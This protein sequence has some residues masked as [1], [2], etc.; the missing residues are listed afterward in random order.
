MG[1]PMTREHGQD[2]DIEAIKTIHRSGNSLAIYLP[3]E[4]ANHGFSH[5]SKI[6]I[7]VRDDIVILR[8][9]E[10]SSYPSVVKA[11]K[12]NGRTLVPLI[13]KG[14]KSGRYEDKFIKKLKNNDIVIITHDHFFNK[15][16]LLY[17]VRTTK[18]WRY[19]YIDEETLKKITSSS[20]LTFVQDLL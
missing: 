14:H 4:L 11:L 2:Y 8:P 5:G 18:E 10:V 15:L 1:I 9:V 20:D 3:K 17:F 19:S 16:I 13:E 6:K 12:W 7:T